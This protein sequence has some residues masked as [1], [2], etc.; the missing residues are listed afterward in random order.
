M[1]N[2]FIA[3]TFFLMS[4]VN[5]ITNQIF[6]PSK[7]MENRILPNELKT[8][9]QEFASWFHQDWKIL[10]GDA[11]S[12]AKTYF[13]GLSPERRKRLR[14]ELLVFLEGEKNS[15]ANNLLRSWYGLGA[16]GWQTN[17]D[18]RNTLFSFARKLD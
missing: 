8:E 14:I 15:T 6:L 7:N 13:S 17:I 3:I 11:Q 9:L 18:L 12:C 2:I 10:F 5:A 4:P 16:Q 1:K